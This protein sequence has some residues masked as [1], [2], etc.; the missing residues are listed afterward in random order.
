[1]TALASLR[2]VHIAAGALALLVLGVP[3]LSRKG[4]KLH[5]GFGRV[6]VYAMGVVAV[7]GVPLAAYGLSDPNP[8]RR[9]NALFLLF[10]ALFASESAWTGMRA[11]RAMRDASQSRR[12]LD[13]V[14]PTLLLAASLGL[15][16]LGIAEGSVLYLAFALLGVAISTGRIAF[17]RKPARS[18]ADAIVQHIGGMGVSSITTFTAFVITNGRYLFHLRAFTVALW[19][20]PV[21]L[22]A[23]AL[24]AAQRKWRAQ[25]ERGNPA[26]GEGALEP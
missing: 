6:Y 16:G 10:V 2:V 4:S 13:L 3:L 24:G 8:T 5:V 19:L 1:M 25:L 26:L 7:T 14:T 11:L 23:V 20:V 12:S 17:W 22:G 18:R 21:F 9:A 15:L